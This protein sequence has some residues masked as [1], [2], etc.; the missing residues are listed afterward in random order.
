MSPSN[1]SI[2]RLDKSKQIACMACVKDRK[3]CIRKLGEDNIVLA[4][5][6]ALYRKDT[7]TFEQVAY[8]RRPPGGVPPLPYTHRSIG[9]LEMRQG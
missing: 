4:P 9:R 5:L 8:F 6:S 2:L 7:S 3:L 1:T